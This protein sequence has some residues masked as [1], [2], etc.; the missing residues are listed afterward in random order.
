MPTRSAGNGFESPQHRQ[1]LPD[2]EMNRI[3]IVLAER[4]GQLFAVEDFAKVKP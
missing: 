1:N 3:G 4:D 2:P